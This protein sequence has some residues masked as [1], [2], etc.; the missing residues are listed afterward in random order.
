MTLSF[1]VPTLETPRLTLRAPRE[2]DLP[3]MI[4]FGG[5][6]RTRYIGGPSTPEEMRDVLD[7]TIRT[8]VT[9]GYSWWT[10]EHRATGRVAGRCGI[11]HP[12][13]HPEPELGWHIYEGFEAQGYAFEAATAARRHANGAM[14][15][16]P[17]VSLIDPENARSLALAARLGA[18]FERMGAVEGH[19]CQIWRHPQ[20]TA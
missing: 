17:L 4:A 7:A 9:R 10:V 19:P 14:G 1:A 15:L 6:D 5:S 13:G 16:G 12:G 8:W 18:A 11:G 20:V 2:A 3:A